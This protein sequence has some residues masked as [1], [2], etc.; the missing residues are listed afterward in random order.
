M[1]HPVRRWSVSRTEVGEVTL[2]GNAGADVTISDAALTLRT[3]AGEV[4]EI[5]LRGTLTPE[6]W[7]AVDAQ[8]AFHLSAAVRGPGRIASGPVVVDLVL[9]AS[10][11]V[12]LLLGCEGVDDMAERLRSGPANAEPLRVDDW[13]LASA[14]VAQG[15]VFRG[16]QT[17]W[18]RLG[19]APDRAAE[20]AF[21]G[22]TAP[23][24]VELVPRPPPGVRPAGTRRR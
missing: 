12:A 3:V 19:R 21:A 23:V 20:L 22:Q 9:G 18:G 13:F 7:G 14:A 24:E 6:T 5:R 10:P 8:S 17:A 1:G 2:Q 15:R 4:N 11:T 16:F